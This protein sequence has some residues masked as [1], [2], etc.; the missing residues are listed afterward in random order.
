MPYFGKLPRTDFPRLEWNTIH[1]DPYSPQHYK[2]TIIKTGKRHSS[3]LKVV[4]IVVFNAVL[5]NQVNNMHFTLQSCDEKIKSI[6]ISNFENPYTFLKEESQYI[7]S[8]TYSIW[9]Q[10]ND[11]DIFNLY[12]NICST[13]KIKEKYKYTPREYSIKNLYY[14]PIYEGLY[15]AKSMDERLLI[16]NS[17]SPS[18]EITKSLIQ[19]CYKDKSLPKVERKSIISKYQYILDSI[20]ESGKNIFYY[21]VKSVKEMIFCCKHH[22]KYL[23]Q[24]INHFLVSTD[25]YIPTPIDYIIGRKEEIN[26][27]TY[28][29]NNGFIEETVKL[30]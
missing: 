2:K 4:S 26:D 19:Y 9:K 10:Y 30:E 5:N 23:K 12:K 27:C 13:L 15:N 21:T 6:I 24:I 1:Y 16:I 11:S 14:L 22:I 29:E 3:A 25:N 28:I 8:L 20:K 18:D 17:I 7:K